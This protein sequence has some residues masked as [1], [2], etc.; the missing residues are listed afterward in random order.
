MIKR[1]F[2]WASNKFKPNKPKRE[3]FPNSYEVWISVDHPQVIGHVT[4]FPMLIDANSKQHA[5]EQLRTKL[6]FFI[7]GARKIN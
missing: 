4:S 7:G 3:I 5:R 6:T 1:F 2:T